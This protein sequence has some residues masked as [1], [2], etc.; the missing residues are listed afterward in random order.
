MNEVP[1]VG[2]T[3]DSGWNSNHL[4]FASSPASGSRSK[5]LTLQYD[6]GQRMII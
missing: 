5:G 2:D 4:T 3:L 1:V 6:E